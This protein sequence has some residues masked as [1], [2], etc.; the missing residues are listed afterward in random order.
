MNLM[1]II[2]H[3]ERQ[4]RWNLM[5]TAQVKCSSLSYVIASSS[6]M[7][8]MKNPK[9]TMVMWNTVHWKTGLVKMPHGDINVVFCD[10]L[11]Y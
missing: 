1:V 8:H 6:I 10:Q 5:H 2:Q 9:P 4:S 3:P 11:T 7:L